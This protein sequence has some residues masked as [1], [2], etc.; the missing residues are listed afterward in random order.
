[1]R[2]GRTLPAATVGA[3]VA[4]ALVPAGAS[5]LD[6]D[7][8]DFSNQAEAQEYLLPGDPYNLDG[9]NDGIACEDLPCPCSSTGGD[10]GSDDDVTPPPP[11]EL[12]KPAARRAAKHKARRY[13]RRHR[14]VQT[15]TFKG[16]GRRSRHKVVCRFVLH[17]HDGTVCRMRIRVRGEGS[18]AHARI[19]RV[20]CR[21]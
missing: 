6:Y 20:R 5:A 10:G 19:A 15:L 16:C 14:N 13:V 17:G 11:E 1:M 9:D 4:L 18:D 3:L 2:L 21:Q 7:C 8:A 12:S